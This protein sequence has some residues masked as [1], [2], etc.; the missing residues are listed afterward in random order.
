MAW[1]KD[2]PLRF[3]LVPTELFTP[4]TTDGPRIEL[5]WTREGNEQT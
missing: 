3:R 2:D 5:S 1:T 4:T